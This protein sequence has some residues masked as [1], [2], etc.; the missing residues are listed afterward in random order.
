M[1]SS[2]GDVVIPAGHRQLSGVLDVPADAQGLVLFAHSSRLSPRNRFLAQV[3]HEA[4]FGT[5]SADLLTPAEAPL[6]PEA[7]DIDLLADRILQ[8][9]SWLQGLS[10]IGLLPVALFGAGV[11]SAA[12]LAVAASNPG[13]FRAIVC[14]GGRPD[15][16]WD[17]LPQ[18][19]APTLFV[20]GSRDAEALQCCQ[21]AETR[22][23]CVS[24]V[25]VIAGAT[26]LLDEPGALN[27]LAE[28]SLRWFER[29]LPVDRHA[30]AE[31]IDVE[32]TLYAL[33][34]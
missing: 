32:S 21:N 3:L 19:E 4:G 18:V 20:V 17:A 33:E 28:H 14:R 7:I 6:S 8:A 26:Y 11:G 31:E 10:N 5:L 16:A 27:A 15:L 24:Q 9:A 2:M 25:R 13:W 23:Q 34:V 30:D 22:L 1:F 29:Y 12:A